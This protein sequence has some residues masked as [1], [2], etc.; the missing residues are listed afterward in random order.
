MARGSS[1][2]WW[3]WNGV[4]EKQSFRA[5]AIP[6]KVNRGKRVG[7][8]GKEMIVVPGKDSIDAS[9]V[10]SKLVSI[11]ATTVTAVRSLMTSIT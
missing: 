2:E 4:V 3:N 6:E 11:T 5:L 9:M 1:E 10:G 8:G 7:Q